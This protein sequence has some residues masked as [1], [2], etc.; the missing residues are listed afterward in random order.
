MAKIDALKERHN[1]YKELF[2]A[3]VYLILAVLTAQ[4]TLIYQILIHKI[5]AYMIFLGILGLVV[6]FLLLL[7]AKMVW[8]AM[9]KIEMELENV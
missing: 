1:R 9:E 2:K 4:V 8:Q 6:T 3:F 5:P 7:F